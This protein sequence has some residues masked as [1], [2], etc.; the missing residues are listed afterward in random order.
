[1]IAPIAPKRA[2]KNPSLTADS[3]PTES[4]SLGCYHAISIKTN[5]YKRV[6][7]SSFSILDYLNIL[8][9]PPPPFPLYITNPWAVFIIIIYLLAETPKPLVCPP[10]RP[11]PPA[12]ATLAGGRGGGS[13]LFLLLLGRWDM[14]FEWMV[15]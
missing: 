5:I 3:L 10:R 1:M 7:L 14:N 11:P 12:T 15:L 4:L 8:Y 6:F 13:L 9:P 2:N